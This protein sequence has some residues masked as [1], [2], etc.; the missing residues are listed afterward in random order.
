MTLDIKVK[1]KIELYLSFKQTKAFS[2]NHA[3]IS[4]EFQHLERI[5]LL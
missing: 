5:L 1:I 2:E 4:E 3:A